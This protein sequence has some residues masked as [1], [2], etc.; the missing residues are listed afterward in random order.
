MQI[1][2]MHRDGVK[3]NYHRGIE[4]IM[5]DTFLDPL[6][7]FDVANLCAAVLS[8]VLSAGQSENNDYEKESRDTFV[9][10]RS[11]DKVQRQSQHDDDPNADLFSPCKVKIRIEET[12]DDWDYFA[13]FQD[14]IDDNL[15]SSP[16]STRKSTK[17][18]DTLNESEEEDD[19]EGDHFF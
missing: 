8:L 18:L 7:V 17:V 5:E 16:F 1:R 15:S 10:S 13:D 19:S 12:H 6:R 11:T 2:R 4:A 3:R 9:G 14:Q